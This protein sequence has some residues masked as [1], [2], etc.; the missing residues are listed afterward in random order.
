MNLI[1][2]IAILVAVWAVVMLILLSMLQAASETPARKLCG[3]DDEYVDDCPICEGELEFLAGQ[4]AEVHLERP[5]L[6]LVK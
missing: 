4:L 3:H 1:A 5:D 6:R 2:I